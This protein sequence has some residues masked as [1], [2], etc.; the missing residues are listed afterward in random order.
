MTFWTLSA[1]GAVDS[2]EDLAEQ[3][4]ATEGRFIMTSGA[5]VESV[6]ATGTTG[7]VVSACH[8]GNLLVWE[9]GHI[10][11]EVSRKDGSTC[12]DGQINAIVAEEGELI[13]IG[14]DGWIRVW[15]LESISNAR[16]TGSESDKSIFHL[17]PMNEVEVEPGADLKSIA[18]SKILAEDNNDWYIQDGSG[19]I[20]KVDL[21]FSLSMQKPSRIYRFF[22]PFSSLNFSIS[23]FNFRCHAGEVTSLTGSRMSSLV[24]S[25]GL[26]GKA[27]IYD[28][29]RKVLVN[30]VQYSSSV[31]TIRWLP[32][33]VI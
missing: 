22:N 9:E 13:T 1:S 8:W 24:L 21:S 18:K 3:L 14:C 25:G 28:I 17:D 26:D 20:W 27:C 30:H 6:A 11:L 10:Q 33:E 15:D 23:N 29:N 32:L 7:K 31:T 2:K 4:R 16:A 5:D 19:S 12:H